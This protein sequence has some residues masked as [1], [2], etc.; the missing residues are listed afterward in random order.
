MPLKFLRRPGVALVLPEAVTIGRPIPVQATVI[1]GRWPVR[2]TGGRL[3][4]RAWRTAPTLGT[5]AYGTRAVVGSPD[6]VVTAPLAVPAEVGPKSR[7]ALD[8]A[9]PTDTA[10]LGPTCRAG[11]VGVTYEVRAVL[12]LAEGDAAKGIR[13][14]VLRNDAD[15]YARTADHRDTWGTDPTGDLAVTVTPPAV[16]VAGR[17][18]GTV[19]VT[20]GS[21]EVAVGLV[22]RAEFTQPTVPGLVDVDESIEASTRLTVPA[23]GGPVPFELDAPDQPTCQDAS[24]FTLRWLVFARVRHAAVRTEVNVFSAV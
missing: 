17:I 22:R 15:L 24:R 8:G 20:A 18:T 9:L 4:L 10:A 19:T 1:T 14:I 2:I 5:G 23:G 16:K 3:E 12:D 13:N 7:T 21:D 11:P 6:T